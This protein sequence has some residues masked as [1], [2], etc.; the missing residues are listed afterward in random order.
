M[1]QNDG[2][3]ARRAL[4]LEAFGWFL[5]LDGFVVLWLCGFAF[6]AI[7]YN[8]FGELMISTLLDFRVSWHRSFV[9]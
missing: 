1:K 9:Q 7:V 5:T 3:R 6:V 8:S 2:D 4:I